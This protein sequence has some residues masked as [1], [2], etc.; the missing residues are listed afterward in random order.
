MGRK[1]TRHNGRSGKNGVYNVRHNDRRFDVGNSDHIDPDKTGDN[2][3]WDCFGGLYRTEEQED[4][5]SFAEVEK[6]FYEVRYRDFTEKQNARN[7]A[8]RHPEKNRTPEHLRT[9]KRTCPEETIYQMGTLGDSESPEVLCAVATEFFAEFNARFGKHVHILDW[10]L[11]L[12]EG[13]PHIQERHVFDCENKYG[14]TAPQ[15]E[16]ALELLDIPLPDPEKPKGKYNNRKMTFD[17]ICRTMLFDICKAHGVYLDEEPSYG[18][19]AYLEKQDYIRM[20]QKEEIEKQGEVIQS[21]DAV[22]S[23][24]AGRLDELTMKISDAEDLINEV[25]DA[26]YEKA[27]EAVADMVQAE[28]HEQDLHVLEEYRKWLLSPER[29]APKPQREFAVRHLESV[30]E[31][32]RN[33]FRKVRE[34]IRSL[35]K[36]PKKR[37]E[38]LAPVKEQARYSLLA[39]LK[40]ARAE[41]NANAGARKQERHPTRRR[42]EPTIGL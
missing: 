35:L 3:Y 2:L 36:D 14:E 4:H 17:D 5:L 39:F 32:I 1:L 29:K 25:A 37:S 20:K 21:Q 28:T 11:H 22:I 34:K 31:K 33:S 16:K 13:T 30:K 27:I 15:Q 38:V 41:A 40:E 23:E 7:E 8:R 9:D 6:R 26:A 10:A 12:D 19:R 18:G 24:K 42:K